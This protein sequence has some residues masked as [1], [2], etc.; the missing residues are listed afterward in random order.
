MMIMDLS[1]FTKI[2]ESDTSHMQ[3]NVAIDLSTAFHAKAACFNP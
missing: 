1:L 3:L 2:P